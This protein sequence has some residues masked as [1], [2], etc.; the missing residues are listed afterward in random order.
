MSER[1]AAMMGTL[2]A[3]ERRHPGIAELFR[4]A[5]PRQLCQGA[6]R[7]ALEIASVEPVIPPERVQERAL[8]LQFAAWMRDAVKRDADRF[9][10]DW[11][12]GRV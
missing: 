4:R 9:A 10:A 5:T 3:F 6:A 12:E 11:V 8:G 1:Y 7:Y 2:A